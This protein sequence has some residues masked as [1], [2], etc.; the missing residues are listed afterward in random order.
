[1]LLFFFFT[2]RQEQVISNVCYNM[3]SIK[4]PI[5]KKKLMERIQQQALQH[6]WKKT[7]YVFCYGGGLPPKENKNSKASLENSITHAECLNS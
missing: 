7:F 5:M 2:S 1:M 6:G 4:M 3:Y